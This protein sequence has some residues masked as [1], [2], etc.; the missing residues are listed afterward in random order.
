MIAPARHG[1]GWQGITIRDSANSGVAVSLPRGPFI[2][3]RINSTSLQ[4]EL[5]FAPL[6]KFC[7]QDIVTRKYEQINL[8]LVLRINSSIGKQICY[9]TCRILV[10]QNISY[11]RQFPRS[12]P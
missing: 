6:D 2:F 12:R 4:Q 1:R 5:Q 8:Q 7:E 9:L 10:R 3:P 11:S